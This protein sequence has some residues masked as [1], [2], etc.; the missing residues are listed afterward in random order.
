MSA[1]ELYRLK[2]EALLSRGAS[3]DAQAQDCFEQAITEAREQE[4]RS[5]NCARR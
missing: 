1:A 4:A 2:G 3:L 5:W